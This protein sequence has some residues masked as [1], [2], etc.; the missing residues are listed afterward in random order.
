[1]ELM[2]KCYCIVWLDPVTLTAVSASLHSEGPGGITRRNNG[3]IPAVV[4]QHSAN[5]YAEARKRV[6]L[7]LTAVAQYDN[8]YTRVLKLLMEAGFDI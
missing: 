7:H 1:M 3:R 4:V 2:A 5:T 6:K 8:G